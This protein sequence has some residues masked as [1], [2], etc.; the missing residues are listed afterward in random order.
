MGAPPVELTTCPYRTPTAP[1][2][3]DIQPGSGKIKGVPPG[4]VYIHCPLPTAKPFNHD[5]NAKGHQ[6]DNDYIPEFL[7]D[8][9]M[10]TG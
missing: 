8:D 6:C 4:Y 1:A 5:V 9:G 10:S 7:T 3:D 2:G